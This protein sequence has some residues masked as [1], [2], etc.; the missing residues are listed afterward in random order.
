M[1]QVSTSIMSRWKR[2][3]L[4]RWISKYGLGKIKKEGR[5]WVWAFGQ[6]TVQTRTVREAM[7][8]AELWFQEHKPKKYD[9]FVRRYQKDLERK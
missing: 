2:D 1:A 5:W 4:G 6:A 8:K 7:I 3:R 9:A